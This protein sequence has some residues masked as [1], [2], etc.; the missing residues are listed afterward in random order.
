MVQQRRK[1][2]ENRRVK[3]RMAATCGAL[4][5]V[6]FAHPASAEPVA[7]VRV[8]TERVNSATATLKAAQQTLADVQRA[9]VGAKG[10][11]GP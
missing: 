1:R 10:Q 5:M 8:M 3:L 6:V 7:P 11:V 4:A 2:A 9:A